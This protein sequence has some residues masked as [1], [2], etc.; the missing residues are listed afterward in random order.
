MKIDILTI[1]PDMFN[2]PMTCSLIS[3]ARKRNILDIN[4]V[5]IR[6]FSKD[7]HNFLF[8]IFF[9]FNLFIKSG[10]YVNNL[11]NTDILSS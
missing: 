8:W 3:K 10:V 2:G 7:K 5:D 9:I 6:S 11:L 1:F 4:C